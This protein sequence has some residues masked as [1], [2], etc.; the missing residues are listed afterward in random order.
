MKS[1]NILILLMFVSTFIYGQDFKPAYQ[2]NYSLDFNSFL[3]G[4]KYAYILLDDKDAQYIVEN[5]SSG[6]AYA[7]SGLLTYLEAIGFEE[8]KWGT[9]ANTPQNYPSICELV[10]I[11]ASW[12]YE[13]ST[14]TDIELSFISCK[15][16]LFT[17]NAAKNIWVNGYTNISTS[18]HNTFM[19]MYG[20]NKN[21]YSS[22]NRLTLNSEMTEWTEDKLKTHFKEKG[23]DPIEGIYESAMGTSLMP[24]YKLGLVKNTDG[25]S[26]IYFSGATNYLDWKTGE[27]KAKL[28]STATATLFKADWY[29]GN[30]AINKNPYITFE[31]GLMNLVMQDRDKT[32]YIKLYPTVT[33]NV[34]TTNTGP[35]SGTGFA[36]ASNGIIVTNHHVVYG[37]TTIK[38]RGIN[39]DFTKL[40]NAKVITEDKNNDLAIIKIDDINFTNLGTIPFLI[41]GKSSDVGTSVFVMGYP[42]RASMGDEIKLTNGII[43]SKSGFQGDVTSYQITAP[44]QPGNSGGPLFDSNG[45]LIGI[46]NAKHT[47]A[48]NASYAIKSTYLLNLFDLMPT[49]PK[50]QTI[51]SVKGKT[52]TE[53][54]KT[55]KKFTYIIEVN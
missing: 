33:E 14:F 23:A 9:R 15:G 17:F 7:I 30:K 24:K 37:A 16:D 6:N 13:N 26:L 4:V 35:A 50:L 40:Y 41:N 32:L 11:S 34:T 5:P 53:Q 54:V 28:Y 47:G 2:S 29:M 25:Y 1:N 36:V 21:T 55:L 31:Q 43:S 45:N 8:V 20:Y 19:K 46:V 42:L 49:A 39:G 10:I 38:I 18:F 44:I 52:L 12:G 51:S 22:Y 27:L 3:G 48:E